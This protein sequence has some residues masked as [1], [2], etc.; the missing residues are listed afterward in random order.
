MQELTPDSLRTAK[1]DEVLSYLNFL[2]G[3]YGESGIDINLDKDKEGN[4]TIKFLKTYTPKPISS[5]E[6]KVNNW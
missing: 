6:L 4:F 1:P 5:I 3:L 2:I